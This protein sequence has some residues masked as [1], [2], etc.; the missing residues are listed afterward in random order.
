[1]LYLDSE[2]TLFQPAQLAPLGSCFPHGDIR[3]LQLPTILPKN[4][5]KSLSE[6]TSAKNSTTGKAR[7]T[8]LHFEQSVE[9]QS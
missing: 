3:T 4:T 9:K 6:S 5:P 1:M 8:N 2:V 7:E